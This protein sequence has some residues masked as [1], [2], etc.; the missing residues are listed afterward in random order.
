MQDVPNA[1]KTRVQ[2]DLLELNEH[3]S[4]MIHGSAKRIPFSETLGSL[5]PAVN[6]DKER[7][8]LSCILQ[9]IGKYCN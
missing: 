4:L 5:W 8:D 2:S 7:T 3:I 1:R 9:K 6:F